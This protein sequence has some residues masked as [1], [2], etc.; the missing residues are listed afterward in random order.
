MNPLIDEKNCDI[1]DDICE[2]AFAEPVIPSKQ[3]TNKLLLCKG[4]V[5]PEDLESF[6]KDE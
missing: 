1:S 3:I 5:K 6:V 2:E 4:S